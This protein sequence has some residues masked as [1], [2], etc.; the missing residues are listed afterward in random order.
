MTRKTEIK[1]YLLVAGLFWSVCVVLAWLMVAIANHH[2]HVE[3]TAIRQAKTLIDRDR[4]FQVWASHHGGIYVP[5]TAK[6]PPNPYLAHIPG[7]DLALADGTSL[8]L[9]NPAYMLRQLHEEFATIFGIRSHLTS[10]NPIRPENGPDPWEQQAL[11]SFA[12]GARERLEFIDYNGQK[13]LRFMQPLTTQKSCLK[14][15]SQQGYKEG[16]IRGGISIAL[17][18]EQLVSESRDQ[19]IYW[20]LAL[21]FL[22]LLGLGGIWFSSRRLVLLLQARDE[23]HAQLTQ[24][25]AELEHKVRERTHS[26]EEINNRLEKKIGENALI[27]EA[28]TAS[29]GELE[30]IFNSAAD[31]LRIVD[32]DYNVVK[33]NTTFTQMTGYGAEELQGRKCYD[34]FPGPFCHTA[35]CPLAK[36]RQGEEIIQEVSKTNRQGHALDCLVQSALFYDSRKKPMGILESFRDISNR[37]ELE[38]RISD[39]ATRNAHQSVDLQQKNSDIIAKNVELEQA[40]HELKATQSQMLQSEKMATVGQLAAGVAHEINNPTGFVT[41]NLTSL[42]KYINR[43]TEFVALI[44]ESAPPEMKA[45]IAQLNKK[46]KIS[47]ITRDIHDLIS[48]SLE[49]S[50]RIKKIVMSLKNFSRQDQEEFGDAN[51]ND[52]MDTTLNVVWNELKYKATVHKEYGDLPLI[53]CYAQQLNQVFMNILV[54]AAQAIKEQGGITIKTWST[55]QTICISITDTGK[56]M[57]EKTMA[58]IF[59]PFFTTKEKDKGTG[60]GLSIA[61]DIITKKHHGKLLVASTLGRG[62]TFTMELPIIKE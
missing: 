54:N 2:L 50:D 38:K 56:G 18:L 17:P 14:C 22:W 12:A 15:H 11:E 39:E 1:N 43:L 61:Y 58:Q 37:K 28:L 31:G 6:T 36:G 5:A 34:V 29:H 55:D 47:F 26:F 8:T 57:E 35:E 62:T 16:D 21:F 13:F 48:E 46:M 24:T 30:Q 9:M 40:L 4:G 27:Q 23:A 52:C 60:L 59:E 42:E 3:H 53:K 32:W 20:G 19:K 49:G 25:Q 51:L 41:S 33:F 10:L 7:R 45:E 44:E